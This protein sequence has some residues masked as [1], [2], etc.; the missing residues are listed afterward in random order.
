MEPK[1]IAQFLW[2]VITI[3]VLPILS[4]YIVEKVWRMRKTKKRIWMY[5]AAVVSSLIAWPLS[6]VFIPLSYIGMPLVMFMA[7]LRIAKL[8]PI[9]SLIA[10]VVFSLIFFALTIVCAFVIFGIVGFS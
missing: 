6:L 3:I 5:V 2:P 9:K 7:M 10:S 1:A 8:P 4:L